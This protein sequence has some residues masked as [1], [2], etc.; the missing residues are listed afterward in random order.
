MIGEE[1][2]AL[3][4]QTKALLRGLSAAWTLK[5]G[6]D[7][8]PSPV[9]LWEDIAP[10]DRVILMAGVAAANKAG[11]PEALASA[12]KRRDEAAIAASLD[13]PA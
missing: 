10:A 5:Y 3:E 8:R 13:S 6:R 9:W 11:T 1:R 4:Q 2:F 7:G 12:R